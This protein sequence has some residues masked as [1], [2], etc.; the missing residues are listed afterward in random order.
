[1]SLLAPP[2]S[3]LNGAPFSLGIVAARYNP[4]LVDGLLA[5]VR[6][7]LAAAGVQGRNITVVRVPGSH[8]V[9][10][11][12]QRLARRRGCHCVIGLGV[13]IAGSTNHHE[14][15]GQ[16]VS[17]ALQQVALATGTPVI[18]GVIVVENLKQARARCLGS[19][20][21]GAEFASAALAMAELKRT[22]GGAA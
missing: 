12:A 7:G 20:N 4:A 19:L 8:E 6:A 3:T 15:V 10:W 9:P 22:N 16:S 17:L 11:A 5:N 21:R 18:N 2:A 14:M 1:M 13:L